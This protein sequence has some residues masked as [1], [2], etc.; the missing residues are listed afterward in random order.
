MGGGGAGPS[1]R[2]VAERAGVSAG[3]VSNV[4]NGK[5]SVAPAISARVRVAVE[6][7]GYFRDNRASRLRS[8]D[9]RLAGVIVPDLTNP[10]FAAFVST[11]EQLGRR[12]G[13]DLVVVS[14][15]NDPA[16]EVER[17]RRIRE[18]RPAGLIVIPCDGA[19]AERLPGGPPMPLV[20]ADRIPDAP[21]FDLVAVD[22]AEAAAAVVRHLGVQGCEDCLV[23]G[24]SLAISNVR[25]RWEG[26]RS[27]AGNLR[28]DFLAVGFDDHAPPALEERLRGAGR[29]QALFCLDH[30]TTLAAYR[31]LGEMGLGAGADV[32]FA[33]FDEMEWMRLVAPAVTTVRQPV[34]AMAACSW[35]MLRRRMGGDAGPPQARR[36]RCAVT[37][38]GSTPRQTASRSR[39]ADRTT[40]G[41]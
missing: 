4:L 25:E 21:R 35:S 1:I 16:E 13:Y 31:L 8:G 28:L 26:A 22:N 3:T 23:V 17:L 38:R 11:L 33:G 36:L 41:G 7:L 9:S 32:A 5:A 6:Q 24:T 37:F 30:E 14:A 27:A 29:P 20:V 12:D 2:L 10:M 18:W 19:L 39:E 34:E 40:Q 15:R